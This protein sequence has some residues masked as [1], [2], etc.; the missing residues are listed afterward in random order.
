MFKNRKLISM[1]LTVSMLL[2]IFPFAAFAED[3]D[4]AGA[5]QNQQGSVNVATTLRKRRMV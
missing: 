3:G 2:T 1:L 5:E 4:A